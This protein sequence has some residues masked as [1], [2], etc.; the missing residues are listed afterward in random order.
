M[1]HA[2]IQVYYALPAPLRTQPLK[3]IVGGAGRAGLLAGLFI[4]TSVLLLATGSDVI[5]GEA[6]TCIG[7][8]DEL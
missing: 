5:G 1:H 7:V 6:E 4:W 3:V 8:G 2:F